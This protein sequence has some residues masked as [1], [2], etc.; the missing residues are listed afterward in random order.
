MKF[1]LTLCCSAANEESPKS[2]PSK[3][4]NWKL[5]LRENADISFLFSLPFCKLTTNF[6]T[7]KQQLNRSCSI[8]FLSHFARILILRLCQSGCVLPFPWSE[9][10]D[11]LQARCCSKSSAFAVD[12]A[13][14]LVALLWQVC[15]KDGV[16]I[17][18]DHWP[19]KNLYWK[20]NWIWI[21]WA[22]LV[23]I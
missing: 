10:Y 12:S 21:L 14:V 22:F 20:W 6:E 16:D 2:G 1:D 4:K 9:A 7:D 19:P 18:P 11:V 23:G 15:G 5:M 3:K 13:M 8:P 17:W